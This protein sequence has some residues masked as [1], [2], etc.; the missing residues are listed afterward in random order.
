MDRL[1]VMV[2]S[3]GVTQLLRVPKSPSGNGESQAS[4]VLHL[5][6]EWSLED[7]I[8]AMGFD[9]TASNTGIFRGACVKLEEM[10]GREILWL[11]CRHHIMELLMTAAWDFLFSSSGPT[12]CLFSRFQNQ[13]PTL[14]QKFSDRM[15]D[16]NL[17][18]ELG[19]E[20]EVILQFVEKQLQLR[21]PR[22]DYRE[23]LVLSKKCLGNR[24]GYL[25]NDDYF[26]IDRN[27]FRR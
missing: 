25:I 1:P 14:N 7:R 2:S 9:T 6:Q 26:N 24:K 10:L 18:Y 5:L 27:T 23:L 19:D 21:Q 3:N 22:D 15:V 12:I 13:W 8:T 4:A 11:A 17:I 20:V 16:Q